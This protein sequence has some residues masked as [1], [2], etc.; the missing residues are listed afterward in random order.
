MRSVCP[1]GSFDCSRAAWHKV[2]V[3]FVKHIS[4]LGNDVHACLTH[5]GHFLCWPLCALICLKFLWLSEMLF[6]LVLAT[7]FLA[8][9]MGFWWFLWL[10][11]L[12]KIWP[13]PTCSKKEPP[14]FGRNAFVSQS[15]HCHWRGV[16]HQRRGAK[17]WS[18]WSIMAAVGRLRDV[19][20]FCGQHKTGAVWNIGW[21]GNVMCSLLELL[22]ILLLSSS[23]NSHVLRLERN[24]IKNANEVPTMI[25]CFTNG[26]W[27]KNRGIFPPNHEF[28]HRVWNHYFHHPTIGG[29]IPLLLVQHPNPD[30]CLAR[31]W[32]PNRARSWW[33][34]RTADLFVRFATK[35]AVRFAE[36]ERKSTVSK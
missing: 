32:N 1:L 33:T 22:M 15:S 31:C 25:S 6:V 19:R 14:Q 36:K 13:S 21:K 12:L 3:I 5:I 34:L 23:L 9:K 24:Q 2:L 4:C 30:F 28:V 8:A 29:K 16:H 17:S 27:T 26:C 11:F 7:C 20:I 10:E 18:R 35:G